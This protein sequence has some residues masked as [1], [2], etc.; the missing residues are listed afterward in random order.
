[1]TLIDRCDVFLCV[2]P[3]REARGP[4]SGWYQTR[5][6]VL[7]RVGDSDGRTG[8]GEASLRPGVVAAAQ[9]LADL[10]LGTEPRHSA[11]LLDRLTATTADQWAVSALAVAV[12][13]LAARQLGVPVYE[14]YGGPRRARVR[15]YASSAGYHASREPEEL[16]PAEAQQAIDDGF[17]AIKFRI[18]RYRP[19]RELAV[20]TD[21]RAEISDGVDFMADGNGAYSLPEAR[22]VGR[23]L[24]DLGYVWFEEPVSRFL[25]N[26]SYP[27]Y[28][29]L[30]GAA[31]VALAGGEGLERRSDF[32]RL[33][34]DGVDIIQPDVSIC[35]GIGEGRFL[36]ELASLYGRGF[37]PHAWGGAVLIAATLQLLALVPEPTE[38]AGNSG[39]FLEWDIFENPMRT[40]LLTEPL[41]VKD[42]WVTVPAGPGLGVEVDQSVVNRFDQLSG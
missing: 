26:L 10:L 36:A 37:I 24:D 15:A 9:Q 34:D 21:I 13:D 4:S 23:Q 33:L 8:W 20:L 25:G 17:D 1:M 38:V 31:G 40:E 29:D 14:L 27:G 39:P 41:T 18:G 5:E 12:D 6:S 16:W 3:V 32:K 22:R 2:S 35:G 30:A 11:A 19:R 28:R 42:G 7:T